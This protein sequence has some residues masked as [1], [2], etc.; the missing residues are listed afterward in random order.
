MGWVVKTDE[1]AKF[2]GYPIR[3]D[4]TVPDTATLPAGKYRIIALYK[5]EYATYSTPSSA[6]F[7]VVE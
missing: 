1:F 7:E 4:G 5:N 3:E 6:V 2:W